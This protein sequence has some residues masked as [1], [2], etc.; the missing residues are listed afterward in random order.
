MTFCLQ[1]SLPSGLRLPLIGT[2]LSSKCWRERPARDSDVEETPQALA[3]C[4]QSR[5]CKYLKKSVSNQNYCFCP[6]PEQN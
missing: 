6:L 4:F 5:C 1:I 3:G 2:A